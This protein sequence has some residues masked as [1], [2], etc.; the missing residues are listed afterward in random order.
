MPDEALLRAKAREAVRTGKLPSRR[1]DRT[2][3]GPA[4]V[5]R[6]RCAARP[7]R[8][9]SWSSRLSSPT[10]ATTPASTSST[11]TSG[12]SRRGSSSGQ[13]MARASS[14]Q[15][16]PRQ[17]AAKDGRALL[18]SGARLLEQSVASIERSGN[19]IIRSRAQW[20]LSHARLE[21]SGT[22]PSPASPLPRPAPLPTRL[23]DRPRRRRLTGLDGRLGAAS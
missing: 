20:L 19:S 11:S 10:M 2:W 6:A 15:A 13:T 21:R 8:R 23:V 12:V 14:D 9:I 17:Q 16:T 3:A 4:S 1:P 5:R 22:E 18:I 7:S